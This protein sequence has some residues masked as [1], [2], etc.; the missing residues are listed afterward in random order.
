LLGAGV[1]TG[2]GFGTLA[3]ASAGVPQNIITGTLLVAGA[4]GLYITGVSLYQNPSVNNIA[5]TGGTLGGG[6]IVGDLMGFSLASALSQD[7]YKPTGEASVLSDINMAWKGGGTWPNPIAFLSDWLLP[8]AATPP[9]TTGPSTVSAGATVAGIG[10]G[11][12]GGAQL[13]IGN[14]STGK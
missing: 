6:S 4:G 13:T 7:G 3:L 10:T 2:I 5:F 1:T 14:S 12:I 9:M 8:G 11:L